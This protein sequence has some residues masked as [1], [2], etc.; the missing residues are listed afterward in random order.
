MF[1]GRLVYL[2]TLADLVNRARRVHLGHLDHKEN[3]AGLDHQDFL[4]SQE[5]EAFLVCR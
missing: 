3:L 4:V 2:E 5:K 1:L